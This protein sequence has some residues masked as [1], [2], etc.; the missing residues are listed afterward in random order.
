[1]DITDSRALN[2]TLTSSHG[3]DS[4]AYNNN[5]KRSDRV[6]DGEVAR[7]S[8]KPHRLQMQSY[9]NGGEEEVARPA[10]TRQHDNT[11][12]RNGREDSNMTVCGALQRTPA[13]AMGPA[14]QRTPLS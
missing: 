13:T 12:S 6:T 4:C 3:C 8:A 2:T 1:M 11:T 5:N 10:T 9:N 14:L 7:H